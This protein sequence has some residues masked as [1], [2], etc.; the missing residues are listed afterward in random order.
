MFTKFLPRTNWLLL[1][2][3]ACAI[4]V[5]PAARAGTVASGF[6][7]NTFPAN[8]DGA[9]GLVTLPFTANYFG[10]DYTG[11]Y[12][13]NNGYI[14]FNF[15]QGTFTPSGLGS[16]YSGQPIIAPFFADVDTRGAGSGLT[17]WGNG[18]Y[19]GRTAFG[20]TWPGVGYFAAHTD[21]LNTFQ[22]IMVDRSDVAAG[23][24]DFYFNYDQIQWETGEASG[25]SNGLGGI[26]AA[27]GYNAGQPGNPAG[28]YAQLAGS[29]TNGALLDGGPDSLVASTNDGVP[30]QFLFQVRNGTITPPVTS[31]PEPSSLMMLLMGLLGLLGLESLHRRRHGFCD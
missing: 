25:G 6:D 24:F 17:S 12:V 30:G 7:A 13:S 10:T 9:S 14:T 23:D 26:S 18:T 22:L 27:A 29:L 31:V 20:A 21:K 4:V 3:I 5:A 16:G 15:P 1:A 8:D 19:A 28:T 2:T 11:L